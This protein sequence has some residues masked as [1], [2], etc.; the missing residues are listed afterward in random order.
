MLLRVTRNDTEDHT[1]FAV[2]DQIKVQCA[3][4]L[5]LA[6]KTPAKQTSRIA[7]SIPFFFRS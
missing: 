4:A 5:L 3:C 7:S 6:V 2:L 1:T